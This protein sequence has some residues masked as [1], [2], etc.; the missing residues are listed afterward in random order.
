MSKVAALMVRE[1][2]TLTLCAPSEYTVLFKYGDSLLSR[3]NSWRIAICGGEAFPI[4][5]KSRF[6]DLGLSKLDVYNAYGRFLAHLNSLCAKLTGSCHRPD[7][8]CSRI[9]RWSGQIPGLSTR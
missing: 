3:L 4:H 1:Q 8:D 6:S 7:G 5:L 2:I 9:K